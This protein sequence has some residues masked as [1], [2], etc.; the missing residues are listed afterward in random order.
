VEKLYACI[1]AQ[2]QRRTKDSTAAEKINS[3]LEKSVF[4]SHAAFSHSIHGLEP[5]I[6]WA[7]RSVSSDVQWMFDAFHA[8]EANLSY[9]NRVYVVL[10]P[11]K[12]SVLQYAMTRWSSSVKGHFPLA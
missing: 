8:G 1:V 10:L 2:A 3:R 4:L 6:Y 7:A 5:S 11:K 9:I 12:D